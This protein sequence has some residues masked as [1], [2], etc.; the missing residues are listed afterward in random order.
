MDPNYGAVIGE[1]GGTSGDE[2]PHGDIRTGQAYMADVVHAFMESPQFSAGRCSSSTTSGAG[3]S[4]TSPRRA[5]RTTACT[6]TSPR[7]S[8][9]WASASPA[10][11]VSPYVKR[12]AVSHTRFGFESILKMIEYRFGIPPLTTRDAYAQNIAHGSTGPRRRAS[13]CRAS[14]GP[15]T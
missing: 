14:R 8:G 15:S 10:V 4:T 12:G 7:T 9:R 6:G 2:H 1:P 11:A 3:S 13:T 5:S